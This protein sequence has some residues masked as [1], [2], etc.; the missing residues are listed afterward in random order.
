MPVIAPSMV[1]LDVKARRIE[2]FDS[3]LQHDEDRLAWCNASGGAV[4]GFV[5]LRP[6]VTQ[7]PGTHQHTST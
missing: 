5:S 1:E 6:I 7:P 3:G 4:L 2:P